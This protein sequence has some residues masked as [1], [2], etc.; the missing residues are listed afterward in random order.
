M[1]TGDNGYD[2]TDITTVSFEEM[3]STTTALAPNLSAAPRSIAYSGKK[4][5]QEE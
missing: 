1:N 2:V 5:A 3:W 4:V